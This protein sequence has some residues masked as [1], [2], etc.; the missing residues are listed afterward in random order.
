MI[1]TVLV[2]ISAGVV[3]VVALACTGDGGGLVATATAAAA[4]CATR[5]SIVVFCL[6][7]ALLI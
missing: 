3:S 2:S 7:V 4:T 6:I 1:F 5:V